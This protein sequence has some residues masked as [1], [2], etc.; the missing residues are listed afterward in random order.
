MNIAT[1][2]GTSTGTFA[3][4]ITGTSG[5]LSRSTPVTLTVNGPTYSVGGAISP[6][7]SGASTLVAL[8]GTSA[9]STTAD[10][11]GGYSFGGLSNGSYLVTPT[12]NGFT[13]SPTNRN[14]TVNG[15]N[16]SGVDFTATQSAN[17]ISI[18]SPSNGA[19]VA[20]KDRF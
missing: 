12:K 14:V 3:L 17:T 5:S 1:A 8:G 11:S 9:A 20:G 7:G 15:G 4:T 6:A 16:V 13:I 18:T 19:T 2:T 10:A